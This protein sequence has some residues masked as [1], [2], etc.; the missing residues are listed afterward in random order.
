VGIKTVVVNGEIALSDGAATGAGSGR[1][2]RFRNDS[3]SPR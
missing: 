1:M 3:F 2:L